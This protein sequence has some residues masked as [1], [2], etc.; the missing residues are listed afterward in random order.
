MQKPV[1]VSLSLIF[2]LCVTMAS[3]ASVT[4]P[5]L[6]STPRLRNALPPASALDM[7]YTLSDRDWMSTTAGEWAM[8]PPPVSSAG[9]SDRPST[10]SRQWVSHEIR[11]A[12]PFDELIYNWKVRIPRDEGFRLYLRVGFPDATHSP[13]LYAGYWGTVSYVPARQSPEFDRGK[14]ACDQLLLTTSA[15]SFQFMLLDDGRKSLSVMP[16]LRAIVT[17]NSASEALRSEFLLS[18]TTS[19]VPGC[20]HDVP[21]RPQVDVAGN[22]LPERCQS[23]ALA[24]ALQY[25]GTT[26]PLEQIICW[27]TDPEYA[28]FGI[29]PRTIG[30]AIELG[31]DAYIDRFRNWDKVRRTVA[32]NKIIL[33]SITMPPNDSYLAPPYPSME[34]HIVALCGV[35]DDNRVVVTD[36]ALAS[37]GRGYL[38]QWLLPDFEK[39]WMRNKG[40]V[41]MVICPPKGFVP[42]TVSQ[43]PPFPRPIGSVGWPEDKPTSAPASAAEAVLHPAPTAPADRLLSASAETVAKKVRRQP[44]SLRATRQR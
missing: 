27:T 32:E 5:T 11:T 12:F 40:G 2:L 18:E 20:I 44:Q 14:L 21:L 34:G 23:A 29:W 36:S 25:F 31:F 38:T 13:W 8:V 19:T 26:V 43:L 6:L 7:D 33:C 37:G 1:T 35:T 4:T 9:G 30:T 16:E 10:A 3:G 39:I 42:R 24:A 17:A 22:K 28:N 41:G 15:L